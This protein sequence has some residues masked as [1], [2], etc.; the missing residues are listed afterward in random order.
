M[1]FCHTYLPEATTD[2]RGSRTE[3]DLKY[4]DTMKTRIPWHEVVSLRDDLK[5]GEL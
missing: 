5:S 1:K 2:N 3:M 4:A